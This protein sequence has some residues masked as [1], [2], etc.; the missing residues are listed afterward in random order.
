MQRL[1][2]A[3]AVNPKAKTKDNKTIVIYRSKHR[4]LTTETLKVLAEALVH[5]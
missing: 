5:C 4:R 1:S 2:N 3:V